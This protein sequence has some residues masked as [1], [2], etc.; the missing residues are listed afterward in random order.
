[1]DALGFHR[2]NEA[3]FQE[4]DYDY[5]ELHYDAQNFWNVLGWF[6]GLGVPVGIIRITSSVLIIVTE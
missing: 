2:F 4:D 1:M 5:S 3:L 6:P